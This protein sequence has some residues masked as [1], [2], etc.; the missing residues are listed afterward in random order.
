MVERHCSGVILAGGANMRFG[1]A[2][3]GLSVIDGRRV[4]DRVLDALAGVVDERFIITN[5]A[6]IRNAVREVAAY[7]D[8]RAERGSLVGLHSALRHCRT[9]AVV[10]AWDMPFVPAALLAHLREVGERAG[11]AAI[12]IGPSGPEPLCAY[13]PRTVLPTVER[14]LDAGN[15]RLSHLVATLADAVLV[16]AHEMAR[17]G[18]PELLFANVNTEADLE[19]ARAR[20]VAAAHSTFIS[21]AEHR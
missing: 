6:A 5:D 14:H 8:E 15:L 10:V 13:Y 11:T 3:K 21:L 17:F 20:G 7:G 9:A 1:G 18:P 4:I 2:P 16:P 12:P 19:A